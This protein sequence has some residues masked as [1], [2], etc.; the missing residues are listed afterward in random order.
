MATKTQRILWIDNSKFVAIFCVVLGHSF[1]LIKGNFCGYEDFNLLIVA[2]NMPLFAFLSGFT[3]YKSLMR[4]N[5]MNDFISY[6]N[7]IAWH[8]GV[9]TVIYTLIAMSIGYGMQSRLERC[10]YSVTLLSIICI[11]IY[12]SVFSKYAYKLD[13]IKIILPYLILPICLVNQS[14]WYFVYVLF[15]L[16]IAA[17]SSFASNKFSKYKNLLFCIYFAIGSMICAYYSPFYSTIEFFI[18]FIVGYLYSSKRG[19]KPFSKNSRI[20][21]GITILGCI[22]G[23]WSFSNYYSTNNQFYLLNLP[24]AI[25]SGAISIFVLRQ[26]CAISFS[27]AIVSFVQLVS[28]SYHYISTIGA[29]TFGIYPIH[30]EIIGI[31]KSYFGKITFGDVFFDILFV[32]LSSF[33]LMIASIQ[34]VLCLNKSSY[35]K[36]ILLG[37]KYA[38]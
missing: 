26:I 12:L 11:I 32:L 9:P 36:L 7:K 16:F 21:C 4:I 35:C 17:L 25:D 34:I 10:L 18:P 33:V 31:A 37:E 28:T 3:S 5:S 23:I 22:I 29:M 2:F 15:T 8:I 14:V 38:C 13:R 30:S 19:L 1:S 24:Q 6:L 27:V 20:L